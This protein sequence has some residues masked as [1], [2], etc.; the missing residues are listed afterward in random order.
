MPLQSDLFKGDPRLESCLINDAAHVK[1]GAVGDYV[2]KIQVAL[3]R[4]DSLLVDP[5]ELRAKWYGPSTA[6]AVLAFKR[7]RGIINYSYQTEPDN[8]VGKMT[9]AALDREMLGKGNSY[10]Q[11]E[12][13]RCGNG[14]PRNQALVMLIQ[15]RLIADYQEAGRSEFA[16]T[17]FA[18]PGSGP[19]LGGF[20]TVGGSAP[21]AGGGGTSLT[22]PTSLKP[23]I[24]SAH[25]AAVRSVFGFSVD[26]GRVFVTN[27][28]GM[29]RRPFTVAATL[30]K[31]T[32]AFQVIN[33]GPTPSQNDMI[34]EMAHVWQSQHH[35]IPIAF[36][37]NCINS[38]A[39]ALALNTVAA[40]IDPTVKSDPDFP[41]DYPNS[42]YAYRPGRG[43]SAYAGEQIAHQVDQGETA[44]ISIIKAGVPGVTEAANMASL[45]FP[46][47]EDR[48]SPGIHS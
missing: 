13:R 48:R 26:Y 4:I 7:K 28:L 38:M 39:A 14:D 25:E 18:S 37:A 8:I 9:I 35:L 11:D 32:V 41:T 44:I 22:L 43:F 36:M 45:T 46:R 12:K 16:L 2:S 34:H 24:G 20:G 10:P 3:L 19:H 1:Q 15:L 29:S 5:S 17:A 33:A 47:T 21:S 40:A 27:M 6:A 42:A 30:P 31:S 23:F